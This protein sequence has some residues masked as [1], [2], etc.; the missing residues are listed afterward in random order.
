MNEQ[1][2]IAL[3]QWIAKNNP[4]LFDALAQRVGATGIG[5]WTDVLKNI[6]SS[7]GTAVKSVGTFIASPDGLK[8]ISEL[9]GAYLQTQA[10]KDA[11][12][13][14]I[15][16][17]RNAQPPLPIGTVVDPNTGQPVPT[18]FPPTGGAVPISPSVYGQLRP[19]PD[20]QNILLWGGLALAGVFI[21]YTLS[22]R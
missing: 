20:W 16:Q 4:R 10:Q 8:T 17:A 3:A 6:G 5:A 22:R 1:A 18:Y 9:S 14:Q 7:V 21:I 15:A 11:L 19:A 13:L 12:R 2:A